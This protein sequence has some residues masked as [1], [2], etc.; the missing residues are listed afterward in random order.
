MRTNFTNPDAAYMFLPAYTGAIKPS[1]P[2]ITF[3]GNCFE[4]ITF[5][6][7]YDP[8]T[9]DVFHVTATTE[10]PRSA[11]C[12]DFFL[13]GN[14]EIIHTEE[15]L[16][17]G[18]HKLTFKAEGKDAQEDVKVNG[19]ETYLFCED[20]REELVSVI[21]T[22]KAFV[23]GLGMHGKIPLFQPKVPEYMEKANLE[24]LKEAVDIEF[25]ERTT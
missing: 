18:T 19:L 5:E 2:K 6:M 10:K 7:D 1:N 4:T 3:E 13:F 9:P 17:R 21:N 22:A 11:K 12:S 24:F 23:G 16:T 15:F 8:S 20:L 14:T 25:E